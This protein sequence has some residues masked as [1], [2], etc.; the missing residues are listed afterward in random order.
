MMLAFSVAKELQ[1]PLK[2]LLAETTYVELI[3][4]QAFFLIQN[5]I[6]KEAMD[7]QSQSR[8]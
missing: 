3:G 7:R 1:M 5:K 4:W 8:G 2:Q 6:R